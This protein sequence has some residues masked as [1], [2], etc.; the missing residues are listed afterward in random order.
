MDDNEQEKVPRIHLSLLE[1]AYD[2]FNESLVKAQQAEEGNLFKW[3]FALLHLVHTIE[4][5]LKQRLYREHPLFI[6]EDIDR[7]TRTVS[8]EKAVT[9]IQG[10]GVH[11]SEDDVLSVRKSIKARNAIMHF[12][13]DLHVNEVR[14]GYLELFDFL[15]TFHTEHLGQEL[16]AQATAENQPTVT[17]LLESVRREFLEYDGEEMHRSWPSKLLAAQKV[18]VIF[19][20]GAEFHRIP[21]GE[22][23]R[24]NQALHQ[25]LISLERC[26]DC[27]CNL[28]QLH[29][30]SCD[31][32]ECPCCGGQLLS[33]DCDFDE[34]E[35]WALI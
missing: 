25:D 5:L 32:E 10:L 33:C 17:W 20:D 24:W 31:M 7:R 14:R 16:S 18:P 21:W 9:R 26:G 8:L 12:E 3:K 13:V 6:Y 19:L 29:G 34:S 4:L 23:N 11:L 28:G 22:E 1:N 2:S 30:P 27:L 15:D 35:L